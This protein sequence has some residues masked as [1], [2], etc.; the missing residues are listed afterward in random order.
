MHRVWVTETRP[1]YR[2]VLGHWEGDLIF[3]KKMTSIGTLVKRHSRYVISLKLP[4]RLRTHRLGGHPV[5][6]DPGHVVREQAG[7]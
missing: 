7:L 2:A 3:G 5:C 4:H 6:A 1:S